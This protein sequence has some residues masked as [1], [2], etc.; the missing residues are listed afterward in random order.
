MRKLWWGRKEG[1]LFSQREQKDL[2]TSGKK[3]KT[4]RQKRMI[5]AI[6]NATEMGRN[7]RMKI[8]DMQTSGQPFLKISVHSKHI[9]TEKQKIEK[10]HFTE[11]PYSLFCKLTDIQT[12]DFMMCT[13]TI[14]KVWKCCTTPSK[15]HCITVLPSFKL[16]N[17]FNTLFK[18]IPIS[19]TFNFRKC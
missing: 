17:N 12:Q 6:Q 4:W 10:Y 14:L 13:Q 19:I 15:H 5:C 11:F 18:W 8:C 16:R 1:K 2:L 7:I 9:S 3:K